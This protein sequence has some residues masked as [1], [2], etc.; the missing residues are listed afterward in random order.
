MSDPAQAFRQRLLAIFADEARDHLRRIEAALGALERADAVGRRG[1]VDEI[2]K[3]LHT[4][5]GAARAVDLDHLER[6]CH[7]LEGLCAALAAAPAAPAP[8]QL[9]Q[10]HQA[11]EVARELAGGAGGRV[12]NRAAALG[13]TLDQSAQRLRTAPALGLKAPGAPAPGAGDAAMAE[14]VDEPG[15]VPGDETGEDP[16][17]DAALP[18]RGPELAIIRIHA[19]QLD[20]IRT[21]A[22]A[23]LACELGLLHQAGELRQLAHDLLQAPGPDGDRHAAA[24][25]G[26]QLRCERLA[27]ALAAD[28][29]AL[30]VVRR[31]LMHA[32]LEAA[33]EPF[34]GALE[35]LPAL[36][37]K[38]ARGRG[39]EVTLHCEG[40][41]VQVDRRV[42]AVLRE[43]LIH[44]VANAVDHGIEPP[45][46]RIAARKN[47][48]GTLRVSASQP[49]A[50]HVLVR[51]EDDGAG[52][53]S[54]ALERAASRAG[55]A[56]A[57]HQLDERARLALALRAGVSTRDEVTPVSG[58]GMGLAVVA[59][60]V[61]SLGGT[62]SIDSRPGAGC[63]FALLLPVSLASMR[64]LVVEA[65][66]R[67]YAAP[68][69]ALDAVHAVPAGSVRLVDGR[70]TLVIDG[71]VLPLVRLASLSG[72]VQEEAVQ[73][74]GTALLTGSGARRFALLVNAIQ[75]EQDVL[76]RGLGPLLR[77]VRYFGGATQL[78]DGSLVPVLALDDLAALAQ[79][80]P[81]APAAPARGEG[82]GGAT[83]RRVLVVEDSVTSRL[84][85]QHVLEGAGYRVEAAAD[86]IEALSRLRHGRIDAVVSDVEMPHMDGLTLTATIRRD[87]ATADL[88]V[89]LLT[90]LQT[91]AERERGLHA[92]ADAYLTKG[93]FDQDQ[94]LQLLGRMT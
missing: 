24:G 78:G 9:D 18:A 90:S 64:A 31:R 26:I 49:D 75:S 32:V 15:D 29:N 5:K 39:R 3:P 12:Q 28:C 80:T 2:L 10:L 14:A 79:G 76:P 86:G 61:A 38:L 13:R 20:A 4:L 47:A 88:P 56:G 72:A 40:G 68:L 19:G 66:G 58:R 35:E 8:E 73:A 94:L 30:S 62:V 69:G 44:L 89:I 27:Q 11:V 43:V 34:A 82:A 21:E 74:H 46:Q 81:T 6:L 7:A 71:R 22:E 70:E 65:G 93:S 42:L 84:L 25:A 87:P 48:A 1:A 33:L 54:A 53:D 51:V 41:E 45:A 52:L 63:S 60:Q 36:V 85:L 92:G 57:A 83:A 67:R 50:R 17:Q 59:D 55:L 16:D 77:R 37:R 23:L 91:P